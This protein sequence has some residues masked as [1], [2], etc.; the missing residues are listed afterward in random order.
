MTALPPDSP[1]GMLETTF[2]SVSGEGPLPTSAE[3]WQAA[4]SMS[5]RDSNRRIG[6]SKR[7]GD[8]G[9]ASSA[10][11]RRRDVVWISNE[12]PGVIPELEELAP[13]RPDLRFRVG[14][15]TF[16]SGD[17]GTELLALAHPHGGDLEW[18]AERPSA[19]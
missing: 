2:E 19:G 14:R 12:G 10:H 13:H 3:G 6:R 4:T 5:R 17:R 1:D 8:Q 9:S 15:T 18:L 7:Q 16:S 11:S